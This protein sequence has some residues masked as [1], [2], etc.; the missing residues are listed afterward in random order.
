MRRGLEFFS[1]Y[2]ILYGIYKKSQFFIRKNKYG[3]KIMKIGK[4]GVL[5]E[6]LEFFWI[7]YDMYQI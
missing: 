1:F 5:D 6:V 3:I 4:F 2:K 7:K